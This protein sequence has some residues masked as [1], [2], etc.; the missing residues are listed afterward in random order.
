MDFEKLFNGASVVFGLIGGFLAGMLGGFDALLIALLSLTVLD[1]ITGIAKAV[2][3]KTL[4][5]NAGFRG[6]LKKVMIFIVIAAACIVQGIVGNSL[7][8]REIVIMFFIANEG[9]SL[10]ENAAV[11][12]PIPEQLKNALIQLRERDK[13]GKDNTKK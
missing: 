8:L 6:L 4:S 12:V 3:S 9:L 11:F 10:L 13:T 5:S 2:Y 1:Y 7:P